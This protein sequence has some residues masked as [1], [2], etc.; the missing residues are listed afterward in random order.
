MITSWLPLRLKYYI[1]LKKNIKDISVPMTVTTN[2]KLV[3]IHKQIN[4]KD[5]NL[6]DLH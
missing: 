2:N 1:T 5:V 4:I 3:K 6:L